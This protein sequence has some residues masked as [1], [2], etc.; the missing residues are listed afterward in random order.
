MIRSPI[1]VSIRCRKVRGTLNVN[2][3]DLSNLAFFRLSTNG[4][5]SAP[6]AASLRGTVP[7][8]SST[9]DSYAHSAI[10]EIDLFGLGLDGPSAGD[11]LFLPLVVR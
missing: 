3:M 11:E 8:E 10:N 7:A 1:T 2:G 9:A 4:L 6:V 5:E